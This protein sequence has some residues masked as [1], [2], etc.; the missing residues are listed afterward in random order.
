L[1]ASGSDG[2]VTVP[3]QVGE[4]NRWKDVVAGDNHA[5]AIRDASGVRTIWCWGNNSAG[6]IGD[7]TKTSRAYPVQEAQGFT[8]WSVVF[9]NGRNTCARRSNRSLWCWG[10]NYYG[11]V[12]NGQSGTGTDVTKPTQV[13]SA[14]DWGNVGMGSGHVCSIKATGT[15]PGSLWCWGANYLGQL[16][17]N[18]TTLQTAPQRE[19]SNA[20]TWNNVSGGANATC[21]TRTDG[22]LWCWGVISPGAV[23]YV[24]TQV[25][26][27]ADWDIVRVHGY[28]ACATKRSPSRT[29]WCWGSNRS[30]QLADGTDTDRAAP[31]QI[32]TATDWNLIA[33]GGDN[34]DSHTCG[35]RTNGT[36]WCWGYDGF[37]QLG[38]GSGGPKIRPTSVGVT[39]WTQVSAGG[40]HAC[41]IDGAG[42]IR[43]WGYNAWGQLGFNY[44]YQQNKEQTPVTVALSATWA[45]VAAGRQN[46]CAKRSDGTVWCWGSDYDGQLGNGTTTVGQNAPTPL[47]VNTATDWA[48]LCVGDAHVCATKNAPNRTLWCW[49]S[50]DEGRLGNGVT[51]GDQASPVQ[52]ATGSV[53]WSQLSCGLRHTCAV[54]TDGT[55]WCWGYNYYGQ[56]GSG[57]SGVGADSS[58]PTREVTLATNWRQVEAGEYATCAVKTDNS[59]WCWGYNFYGELGIG[60]N[61][62]TSTPTRVGTDTDWATV[63]SG[64]NHAC[65]R[66]TNGAIYCW[67]RANK[68]QLGNGATVDKNTPTRVD[69]ATTWAS[70]SA[71]GSFTCGHKSDGSLFCWGR[72]ESGQVGDGTAWREQA[73]LQVRRP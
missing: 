19:S 64:G 37:G 72:N 62:G 26:T 36:L 56:L 2:W 12:G 59:L 68:G 63:S 25:G 39:T 33:V 31:V 22:T 41:A 50:D 7:D 51:T 24:P 20:T 9:A 11:Q 8:D 40:E 38:L 49:G 1:Q 73:P 69:L 35:I 60:N 14:L 48:S 70:V 42:G 52:E 71:G 44:P 54:R 32:G 65:A 29:L 45:Q 61:G 3:R 47:Q 21:A 55:L 27:A 53:L 67:G 17:I 6:Q 43:C 46:T 30:G 4:D 16:G 10:D 58:A 66:K 5:C 23:N 18:N 13:G 34:L 57:T 28:G 15:T